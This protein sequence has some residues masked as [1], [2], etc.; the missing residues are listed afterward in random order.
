M[1]ESNQPRD[2]RVLICGGGIAGMA[3]TLALR[4][5]GIAV[6]LVE[7]DP[8]WR[9]YGAGISIT[10]PTL[11]AFK[12][13]GIL[14]DLLHVGFAGDGIVIC[15]PDGNQI[16][17]IPDPDVGDDT[18]PG[19]GG[20]M[21]PALHQVL[22]DKV[23]AAGASVRLGCTV[24]RVRDEGDRACVELT[25]GSTECYDLVIGADGLN[26]KIRSLIR[27]DA[28]APQYTGQMI[29][30]LFA[31]R[32]PEVQSRQYFLGGRVKIGMCPV[33][34]SHLYLFLLETCPKRP[35]VPDHELPAELGALLE[36]YGGPIAKL[37]EGLHPASQIIVRPLEAFAM[38]PPWHVG[39]TVL[40]GDAAHPTTPQL[41]SGAGMAVEDALVLADELEKA[42]WDIP[43]MLS[44]FEARRWDRCRS[45][46]E[47]S[48][49]IGRL[50]QQG[51]PPAQQTLL[52]NRTLQL[53]AEPL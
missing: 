38:P 15:S 32:P 41:A 25:D 51:A 1:T 6:D 47:T 21:R 5:R 9:V 26:S 35:I 23:R 4:A 37:R 36:G 10:R 22:A 48:I 17:W 53:L 46:V 30:R 42:N 18:V 29:W 44:A 19:S 49:E 50:E 27:P 34:S 31:P 12:Q 28:P 8:E 33:S 20:I 16:D 52:V 40:I 24:A 2:L 13:L 7:I 11:R 39:R 14:D 43:R 45:V 3:S